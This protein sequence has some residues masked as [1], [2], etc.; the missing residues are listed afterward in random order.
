MELGT[1]HYA[2]TGR[3]FGKTSC[4]IECA[5]IKIHYFCLQ[6]FGLFVQ[7]FLRE[8][9]DFIIPRLCCVCNEK[10]KTEEEYVCPSCFLNFSLASGERINSEFKRKFENIS[11]ID[12]FLSL[13][14]FEKD[15]AIQEL[16]HSIKYR[17]KFK[18]G[19]YLGSLAALQFNHQLA[20]WNINSII[21]VP[22]HPVKKAERG[23][24][25]SY[26]IAKG[27]STKLKVPFKPLIL[28]RV[29]YTESQTTM[30]TPERVINMDKAF[31]CR[32]KT[33]SGNYLIIDDVITTGSTL[34]E[35][36]R[37]L[38]EKGADKVYALSLA[39]AD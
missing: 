24:N 11:G 25:Q 29:K 32:R 5:M 13:Y 10:L 19:Y 39:I 27:V 23:Y 30:T 7:V 16:I 38:K 20:A 14:V 36:A 15:A 22:L 8:I 18:A 33:L 2:F 3:M 31:K 26:Y 17:R 34:K 12:S 4:P 21:P 1:I 28:K 35:C 6:Q 37:V 9:F